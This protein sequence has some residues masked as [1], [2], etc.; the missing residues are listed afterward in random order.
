MGE[1]HAL[2]LPVEKLAAQVGFE[3]FDGVTYGA[4]R[5]VKFAPRLSEA[6]A[7]SEADEG[8]E[9]SCV[10]SVVHEFYSYIK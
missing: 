7:A 2:A 8:T 1:M 9:L 4:L 5:E 10:D 6:A 3:R